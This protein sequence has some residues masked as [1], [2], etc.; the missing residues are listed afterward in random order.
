[1][2]NKRRVNIK[3]ESKKL[4]YI[5]I[6]VSIVTI[7][8]FVITYIIYSNFSSKKIT[9]EMNKI[10]EL[11]STNKVGLA[12]TSS[13]NKT[14]KSSEESEEK[15]ETQKIAINTSKIEKQ[16]EENDFINTIVKKDEN[17]LNDDND[18]LNN[19]EDENETKQTSAEIERMPDPTFIKPVDG[20]IIRN[21]S[22][23]SLVYSQTLKEWVVHTGIDIKAEKKTIVKASADGEV[24]LIKEDPRYGLTV[25][26]EHVNGF[27]SIY[28]NLLTAEFIKEGETI[29]QGQTI[30]T[31]GDTAVFEIL[32]E[33]HLHFEILKDNEYLNPSEY[34]E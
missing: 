19:N 1:M 2:R 13:I 5:S 34:I 29:K 25:V 10:T 16:I 17:V 18:I 30:G 4:V 14:E 12:E 15:E 9:A 7:L 31:I 28:S 23:D 6:V 22:I 32:D 21:F 8:A 20:E 3:K 11:A 26:I 27:E 24:K 33:S